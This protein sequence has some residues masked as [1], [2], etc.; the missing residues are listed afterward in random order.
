MMTGLA[1]CRK[2]RKRY[3]ASVLQRAEVLKA[4]HLSSCLL[5]FQSLYITLATLVQS[6]ITCV[7]FNHE[8]ASYSRCTTTTGLHPHQQPDR[9]SSSD[10][11]YALK[12]PCARPPLISF[13]FLSLPAACNAVLFWEWLT[14]FPLEYRY[15]WRA[16]F[17]FTTVVFLLLRYF[18]FVAMGILTW[19][20]FWVSWLCIQRLVVLRSDTP[21]PMLAKSSAD[22]MNLWCFNVCRMDLKKHVKR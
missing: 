8:R 22:T 21:V 14:C 2:L 11:R 16:E 13:W 4:P 12:M 10:W 15:I 9:I 19:L 5:T 3:I 6:H 20:F 18:T 17:R 7:I 1:D